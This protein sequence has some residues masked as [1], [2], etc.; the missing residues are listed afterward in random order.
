MAIVQCGFPETLQNDTALRNLRPI[1]QRIWPALD[2][3]L[4]MGMGGALVR[5]NRWRNPK[6]VC[7]IKWPA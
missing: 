1:R 4:G 2:W 3:R 5:K 7:D 6:V